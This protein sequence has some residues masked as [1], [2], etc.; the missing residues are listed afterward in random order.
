MAA[1]I[2]AT[3]TVGKVGA[4]SVSAPSPPPSKRAGARPSPS[5]SATPKPSK[6]PAD[7]YFG[8]LKMSILGLRHQIDVL[9]KRYDERTISD[10]DLMHDAGFIQDAIDRWRVTY[11]H[12][13]WLPLTSFQELAP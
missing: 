1:S 5:A 8:Q 3:V 7:Q 10:G 6:A 13:P 12:D 2:F 4:A 11:P 9:G